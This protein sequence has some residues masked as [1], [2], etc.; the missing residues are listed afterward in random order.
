M[1]MVP[2]SAFPLQTH[3]GDLIVCIARGVG[4]R[5]VSGETSIMRAGETSFIPAGQRTAF[6][7]RR[8]MFHRS[9]SS[10]WAS[11]NKLLSSTERMHLVR[12]AEADPGDNAVPGR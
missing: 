7:T 3:E 10:R 5:L 4:L 11:P 8:R 12:A 9:S 2:G 6:R 1:E